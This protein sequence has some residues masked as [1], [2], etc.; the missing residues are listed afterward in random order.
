MEKL[1]Q[2]TLRGEPVVILVVSALLSIVF[3]ATEKHLA[4]APRRIVMAACGL[5]Q[6]VGFALLLV[7]TLATLG[8]GDRLSDGIQL[9][10]AAL[11]IGFGLWIF[12]KV[13]RASYGVAEILFGICAAAANAWAPG[14]SALANALTLAASIYVV[15]RGL[16]NVDQGLVGGLWSRLRLRWNEP[17]TNPTPP[18]ASV[19]EP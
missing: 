17:R 7:R 9:G 6:V 8:Q 16:D 10:V 19:G 14:D 4:G 3:L 15:V 1:L 18:P 12:R 5:G 11:A 13:Q 2:M